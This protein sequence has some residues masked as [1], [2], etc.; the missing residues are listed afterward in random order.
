[1][2]LLHEGTLFLGTEVTL[3]EFEMRMLG[4]VGRVRYAN[5]VEHNRVGRGPSA[6]DPT[7]DYHIRGARCEFAASLMLNRYWRPHVGELHKPDVGGC[8][9]VRSTVL[10]APKGRLI[11]RPDAGEYPFML[12]EPQ[13]E[14]FTFRG[15]MMASDAKLWKLETHHNDTVHYVDADALHGL[16][17]LRKHLA[18]EETHE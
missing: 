3:T 7:P 4:F 14:R 16:R 1:M 18:E 5:V 9:E 2:A 8:V 12:I 17:L 10:K 11:V 15:W 6:R 13:G